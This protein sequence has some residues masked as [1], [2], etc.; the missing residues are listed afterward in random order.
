MATG[1]RHPVV[2]THPQTGRKLLYV[3]NN[4]TTRICELAEDESRV[5]LS[6]LLDHIK[7][8][9]FQVR[10]TWSP[11]AMVLWD[12]R[13]T[14]HYAVPD[15]PGHRR[16]HAPRDPRQANAPLIHPFSQSNVGTQSDV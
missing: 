6:F 4:F 3:N 12:N 16:R 5:V 13:C 9:D 14:Q 2:R 11:N 15:V 1:A 10:F 7:R 8:P